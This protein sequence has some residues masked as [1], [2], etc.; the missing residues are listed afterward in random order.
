VIDFS[1]ATWRKST[2][3]QQSGQCVELARVAG[4]IGVRDSKDPDGPV[5][6]FTAE[7]FAAFLDGAA[8]GEF[9]DLA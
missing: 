7:E 9:D 2:R 6:V 3:S 5:L 8:N 1:R 4:M